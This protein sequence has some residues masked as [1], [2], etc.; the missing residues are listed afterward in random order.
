MIDIHCHILPGID[1]GAK[2][3]AD[4]LA[5]AHMAVEEGIETIVVTPHHKNGVYENAKANIITYTEILN[6]LFQSED[7][8]LSLLP[9]QETRINGDMIEDIQND[10]VLTLNHTKYVFVEFPSAHIPAYATQMLFD[11]Q[12]AGYTPII[13]HPE[14]N[15][16]LLE[17]PGKMYDFIRK[18]ALSQVT[19]GSL[20]GKFGKS[21]EKFAHELIE[22]NLTHFIASDAHNTTSRAFWMQDALRAVDQSHGSDISY[23]LMENSQ[24]LVDNMN[25]NKIEPSP[26]KKKKFF[27]L[28]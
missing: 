27:G 26:I 28:F 25:V 13:V 1:D 17:R 5:M 4:S 6:E 18:G 8:P 12:V 3:E 19:T 23:V 16:E 2:T 11:I 20:I 10:D 22:F 7:I 9:G 15:R 24:L 21:I 14:R